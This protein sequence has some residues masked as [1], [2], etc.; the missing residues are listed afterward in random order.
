MRL[1]RTAG[2]TKTY[3]ETSREI[4]LHTL[5][6]DE[7]ETAAE[8]RREEAARFLVRDIVEGLGRALHYTKAT[9]D[10]KLKRVAVDFIMQCGI[11][12]LCDEFVAKAKVLR[13]TCA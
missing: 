3:A 4:A 8:L 7:S 13:V 2:N 10:A 1:T 5:Q 6:D 12:N 9:N 11:Y